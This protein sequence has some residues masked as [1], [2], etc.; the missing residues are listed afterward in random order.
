MEAAA[1]VVVRVVDDV[2]W[3]DQ[4]ERWADAKGEGG[5]KSAG[6]VRRVGDSR[7]ES[8]SH[9]RRTPEGSRVA[10]FNGWGSKGVIGVQRLACTCGL[11][12]NGLLERSERGEFCEG[13]RCL[14]AH[15][16]AAS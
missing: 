16:G 8:S 6:Q 4:S 2:I 9:G 15:E 5:H 11:A 1:V 14:G 3:G 12:Q 10:S 13:S 7:C